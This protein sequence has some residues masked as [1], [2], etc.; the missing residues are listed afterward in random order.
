LWFNWRDIK[1]PD[2]GG[3]EVFTHEVMSRLAKNKGYEMTLFTAVFHG[4]RRNEVLDG[5]NI[6]R[7]GGRYTVYHNAKA[8]YKKHWQNYDI[9]VDE[10]NTKPFLTPKFAKEKPVLALF[11]Q[12]AAEF[13]F[14]E[15]RFPLNY[16]GYYYLERKWLSYYK[17]IPT[18]TVSNSSKEDLKAIGFKN[19]FLVPEG[20]NVTPL[21]DVQQKEA[22]PRLSRNQPFF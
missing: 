13:W 7:H 15:T 20:L 10:I 22:S 11:H 21:R 17:D 6:I 1:N 4:G 14:Y 5:V 12:L 16:I 9:I 8:Y 18:V 2:A 19:I 3:A